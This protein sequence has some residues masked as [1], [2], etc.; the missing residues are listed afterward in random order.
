MWYKTPLLLLIICTSTVPVH[1]CSCVC[2]SQ[3]ATSNIIEQ[4]WLRRIYYL[5]DLCL[6]PLSG[7]YCIYCSTYICTV[8]AVHTLCT[9]TTILL[10]QHRCI[11]MYMYEYGDVGL[12]M[13][14]YVTLYLCRAVGLVTYSGKE[15]KLSLNSKSTPSKLSSVDRI[16]NR[17]LCIAIGLCWCV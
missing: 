3:M 16:V 4:H 2:M 10:R 1:V 6:E 9:T 8:L 15:T 13:Y 12:C 17:T 7:V 14:M 11:Y 5:G